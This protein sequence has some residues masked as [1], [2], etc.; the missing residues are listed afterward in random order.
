M[1]VVSGGLVVDIIVL[2][3]AGAAAFYSFRY[4]NGTPKG[5]VAGIFCLI[6]AIIFLIVLLALAGISLG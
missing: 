3:V 6:C 2:I 4:V 1:V 5:I